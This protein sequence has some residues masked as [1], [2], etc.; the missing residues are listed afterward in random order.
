[1]IGDTADKTAKAYQ[2]GL[3]TRDVA[4]VGGDAFAWQF[5]ASVVIPG[6][7]INRVVTYSREFIERSSSSSSSSSSFSSMSASLH[8]HAVLRTWA[9][10]LIGLSMI[11]F[12]I[13]PIDTCVNK[14]FD[15]VIRPFLGTSELIEAS[16]A[17][18]HPHGP[19]AATMVPVPIATSNSSEN[20]VVPPSLTS[21]HIFTKAQLEA[22]SLYIDVECKEINE[23][24][25]A[26]KAQHMDPEHC[27]KQGKEVM[28]CVAN[29]YR[30]L[31]VSATTEKCFKSYMECLD[32]NGG[33]F[34]KCR[35]A[36]DD[37]DKALENT[38]KK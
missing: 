10:T 5:L 24:F 33:D 2:S 34:S 6:F 11:P 22:M 16:T 21:S 27:L 30:K 7:T 19:L 35:D 29:T 23:K 8:K 1:V 38:F 3:P 37:L 26:C 4:M 12:I 36:K 15:G 18:H 9:P 20:K 32:D 25:N 31:N 17:H 28:L 14:L 13:H